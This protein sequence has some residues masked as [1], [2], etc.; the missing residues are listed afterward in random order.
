MII[1]TF[2][3]DTTGINLIGG[4][5]LLKLLMDRVNPNIAIVI[6]VLRAKLESVKIHSFGNNVDA[7][8]TDMDENYVKI[9]DNHS[10]CESIRR[11][12]L[13]ALLSG[14]NAKFNAFIERIKD[15]IDSQTG[16]NKTMSFDEL[17]TRAR[18]KYNNMDACDEYSKVDPKDAKI[19]AL[20]TRL[21]SIEKYNN[22]N[23]AHATTG[24]GNG[25]NNLYGAGIF[26][27]KPQEL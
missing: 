7:M 3:D 9:L 21:E 18:S 27:K 19:L 23:S 13:N 5:C 6:K 26:K 14:P 25:G 2:E 8:L 24:V 15:D 12:C 4:P 20:T 17:C 16:L 22:A 1:F 11:Y 10:T